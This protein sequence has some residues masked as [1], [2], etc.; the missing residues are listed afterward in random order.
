MRHRPLDELWDGLPGGESFR[1]FHVRVTDG[2]R[3]L[4]DE[5]AS[6][7]SPTTPPLCA[8]AEPA[9]RIVIVAHAG[10]NSV[11]LGHL[12]GIEPVPWEWERF[13]LVPRVGHP[14]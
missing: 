7:R 12:L 5:P 6:S 4:L 2:L 8:L 14:R 9:R 3:R 1:D 11:A 10:T 13:V